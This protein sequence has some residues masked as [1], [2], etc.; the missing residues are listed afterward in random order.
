MTEAAT[1]ETT[2]TETTTASTE[3]TAAPETGGTTEGVT[4]TQDGAQVSTEPQSYQPNFK[5]KVHDKE[6]EIEDWLRGV[7]KD[8]ETEKKLRELH[9]RAYGLDHV[10]SD[11]TKLREQVQAISKDKEAQDQALSALGG[12]LKKKDFD[13][14]FETTNV[15]KDDVLR[16]AVEEAQRRQNPELKA[17]WEQER[18]TSLQMR[19]L[20]A[21]NQSLRANYEQ[22]AVHAREFELSQILG[23]PDVTQTAQAFEARIGRPGAFKEEVARRGF[24][25]WQTT[26]QDMTAE[27]A[28]NEVL[29]LLGVGGN[30]PIVAQVPSAQAAPQGQPGTQAKAPEGK[31]VIPNIQGRG[32][33]PVAKVVKS[34][35]DIRAKA[36]ELSAQRG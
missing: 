16:W 5:F 9:E 7:V 15:S 28:V 4:G 22:A 27:Q 29:Q 13:S 18:T 34:L 8:A 33:S 1:A 10:K 23:R 12:L 17:K 24:L 6:L 3:T 32:T 19:D 21:Q 35:D 25:H 30:G 36:R 26:G 14:F 2:G 20:E 11:R 31:P